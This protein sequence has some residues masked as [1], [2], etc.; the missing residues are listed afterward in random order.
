MNHACF[1]DAKLRK[2]RN[3]Y[4]LHSGYMKRVHSIFQPFLLVNLTEKQQKVLIYEIIVVYLHPKC[5]NN[6]LLISYACG[7]HV[8]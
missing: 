2:N 8:S 7:L 1:H 5:R 4:L 6:Q 3:I